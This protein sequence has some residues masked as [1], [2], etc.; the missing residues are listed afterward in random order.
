[1]INFL[2]F[3]TGMQCHMEIKCRIQF[4]NSISRALLFRL[5]VPPLHPTNDLNIQ[6]FFHRMDLITHVVYI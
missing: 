6:I 2:T 3:K 4:Q 1:M 5:K